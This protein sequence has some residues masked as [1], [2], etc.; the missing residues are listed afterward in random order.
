MISS[1]AASGLPLFVMLTS[2][3]RKPGDYM[4]ESADNNSPEHSLSTQPSPLAA[5]LGEANGPAFNGWMGRAYVH[6]VRVLFAP[7]R[8]SAGLRASPDPF[9]DCILNEQC[10]GG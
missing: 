8:D 10:D 7:R 4:A 5:H 3:A 6:D 2:C 1:A 9:T